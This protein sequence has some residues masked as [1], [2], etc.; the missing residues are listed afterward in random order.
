MLS[1]YLK[2]RVIWTF[3]LI[4][5]FSS[6]STYKQFVRV[7]SQFV[8]CKNSIDTIAVFTDVAAAISAMDGFYSI[9]SSRSLDSLI[10]LGVRK[11]LRLKGYESKKI[12]PLFLGSFLDSTQCV[13]VRRI[14]SKKNDTMKMPYTFSSELP[15]IRLGAFKRT[16][17]RLYLETLFGNGDK[18]ALNVSDSTIKS[19]LETLKHTV[20]GDYLLFVF[21]QTKLVNPELTA[22]LM[23][24]SLVMS[25]VLSGGSLIVGATTTN[26]SYTYIHLLQL[27]TGNILWSNYSYMDAA[28]LYP[29]Y[30]IAMKGNNSLTSYIKPDSLRSEVDR[31]WHGYNLKVFPQKNDVKVLVG[32]ED[33]PEYPS[34]IFFRR[35]V[36]DFSDISNIALVNMIDSTITKLSIS[37]DRIPEIPQDTIE[38]PLG[39]G[40]SEDSMKPVLKAMM[41]YLQYIYYSRLRF[42]A[43]LQGKAT[44]Q[45]VVTND[46]KA[47]KISFL[48]STFDDPVL[49]YGIYKIIRRMNFGQAD[50]NTGST[51]IKRDIEFSCT[52]K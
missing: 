32:S 21:H 12:G 13:P 3:V 43:D 41:R 31:R 7:N 10:Y 50:K 24:G 27:S 18:L 26:V 19:D 9:Q 6:C 15:E 39:K 40:R 4:T 42:R 34:D 1:S 28:P 22:G 35:S 16:S 37:T 45:F 29:F 25:T 33:K 51:L 8:D 47:R 36:S 20:N 44:I 11:S 14:N 48:K 49:E 52:N 5:L 2:V 17:R 23:V 30:R 38:Y 46:G